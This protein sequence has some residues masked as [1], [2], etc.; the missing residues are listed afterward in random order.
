MSI[1]NDFSK[2]QNH[3][4]YFVFDDQTIPT[5]A[6]DK[7]NGIILHSSFSLIF[8]WGPGASLN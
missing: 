4:S 1:S 5:I 2:L 7:D 3:L 6:Q 8:Q